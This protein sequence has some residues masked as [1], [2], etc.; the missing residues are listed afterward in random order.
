M[1]KP[2]VNWS[3]IINHLGEERSQYYNAVSPPIYQTSNFTFDSFEK[4]LQAMQAE[5]KHHIYTRGNNPTVAILRKKIAAL[6]HTDDALIFSS[7]I[8][9]ISAAVCSQVQAGDHI[10][11]VNNVYSWTHT[12]IAEYLVRFGV[13]HTYVDGTKPS[14]IE[15][16][17]QTNTRVLYLE[18]PSTMLFEIQ[19][20]SACAVIAKAS[21]LITI[22]DN[23]FSSPYFQNP[24]DY[25]IDIV[26]HSGSKYI[27][28][29]S[30][31]VCGVLCANQSIVDHI[32]TTEFMTK[33]GI[34]SP[35]EAAL[36]LRGLRTLPIRMEQSYRSTKKIL[37]F[38]N[39][40]PKI[41]KINHPFFDVQKD[42]ASKQMT[43]YGGLFSIQLKTEDWHKIKNFVERLQ[44]F[45]FAVSWGGY[46]S[47][48]FPMAALY[49]PQ[50][51]TIERDYPI[52]LVRFYIGLEDADL[53]IDDLE[54][55]L[56]VI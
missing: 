30:D 52:N 53:L 37:A 19:D 27:N 24:A 43:G 36:I 35:Y 29:H 31:V 18:S 45:L 34:I 1:N 49:D 25:G 10:V 20:L 50:K 56:Q 4:F 13:T 23:S 11:V 5:S 39:D 9:A 28:G 44:F 51:Q 32:F 15:K 14:E 41:E 48:L 47:L 6:E 7:G 33:G 38:L 12:L 26:V 16:A 54:Q 21:N 42:L 40:H 22:I 17:I 2:R 46:E 3:T 55:A 8:A